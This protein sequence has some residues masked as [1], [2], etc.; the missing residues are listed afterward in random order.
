MDPKDP[1]G[2]EE[3]NFALVKRFFSAVERGAAGDEL[4]A[5]LHPDIEQEELPNR[6]VPHGKKRDLA[7][8]KADA[9]KGKKVLTAQRYDILRSYALGNTVI[10]EVEWRGTLAVPLGSIPGGGEMRG[11]IA[12]FIEIEGGRIRRQREYSLFDPF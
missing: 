9:E 2:P 7:A 4:D 3:E 1:R 12:F 10:A 11:H 8:L 5:F 6:L